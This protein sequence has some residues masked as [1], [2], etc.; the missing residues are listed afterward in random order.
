MT[1]PKRWTETGESSELER[2]LLLAGQAARM[3]DSERRALWAGIALSVMAAAPPPATAAPAPATAGSALSAYLT[4]GLV[5]LAAVG[6]VTL[7]AL[8]LWPGNAPIPRP[9]EAASTKS[10]LPA[11]RALPPAVTPVET[12]PEPTPA[13]LARSGDAKARPAPSSRLRE[14]TVAV[15]EARAALRAGN[16]AR[17]L[18]L[19]EQARLRYPRGALGQ[20][21][22]AL[23]IQA[24]AQSGARPEAERRARAFLRAHP[25]SPYVAD[26]RRIAAQ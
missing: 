7:G 11:P 14:E 24:L 8:Q 21:R 6:G 10:A 18:A 9:V 4:K 13:V 17:S 25:Q 20:E 22:E 23:T 3:P 26:V 16:A 1:D 2:E 12:P 19:L 5:F 15:L